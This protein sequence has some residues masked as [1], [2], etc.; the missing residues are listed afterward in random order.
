MLSGALFPVQIL[1][2]DEKAD[3]SCL[4]LFSSSR[5]DTEYRFIGDVIIPCDFSQRLA[6]VNPMKNGWPLYNRY[7][8]MRI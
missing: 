8:P 3:I 1:L 4:F 2:K 6:L 5:D 7:F